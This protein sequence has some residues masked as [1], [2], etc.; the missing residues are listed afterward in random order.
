M[1][2]IGHYQRI[3]LRIL[4]SASAAALCAAAPLRAQTQTTGCSQVL[5]AGYKSLDVP[6]HMYMV[7]SAQTDAR[8]HG[9][10]P[11]VAEEIST[12]GVM[13][14]LVSG[15]KWIKSPVSMAE[16]K[17]MQQDNTDSTKMTC[18]HLRDESVNG[19]PAAVWRGHATTEAGTVDTDIWISKGRG[20]PLKADS[21]IDVGGAMGKSHGVSRY[22]Y[23][24]VRL[25]AGVQ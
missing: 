15:G 2:L 1:K 8:M 12:G 23:T 7:D 6:F 5:S 16:M 3:R 14:V 10:K 18:T 25:P 17:K 20:L 4:V 13:Y 19:E 9:G 22:D 24:N 21:H 11:T